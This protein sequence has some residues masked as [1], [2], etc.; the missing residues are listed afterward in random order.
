VSTAPL[1]KKAFQRV[2]TQEGIV[3]TYA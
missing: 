2:K 3:Y 1:T